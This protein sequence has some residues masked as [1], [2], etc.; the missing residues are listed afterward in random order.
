MPVSNSLIARA[1]FIVCLV[2]AAFWLAWQ[3]VDILLL[4]FAAVLVALALHALAA[5]IARVT[6]LSSRL[7]LIPTI[8]ILLVVL[9]LSSW[10]FGSVIRGQVVDLIARL[11][12]AWQ[13]VQDRFEILN[14]SDALKEK[15]EA[16]VPSGTAVL[17]F[18]SGFTMNVANAALG[19][20][21]ILAGGIYL[22]VQPGLYRDGVLRLAEFVPM[23]GPVAAAVPALL[24]AL[25][26]GVEQAGW[27]LLLF[28]VVQQAESNIL[29]P[30]LQQEMV[31][32]PAAVTLFAVVAFGTVLGPLGVLLATPLTVL[33]FAL[34][35][36]AAEAD[37]T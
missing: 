16:A 2:V 29:A 14:V 5:P 37:P 11:P 1:A 21:L 28:I 19:L 12:G 32:V 22:A 8:L 20:F 24:L 10:L 30:L 31:N 6:G 27:T 18:L 3:V 23:V 17:S 9:G 35:R 36:P 33:I 15:A 34:M 25:N 4:L 7:A 26:G 13:S